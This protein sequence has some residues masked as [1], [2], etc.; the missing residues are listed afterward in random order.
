MKTITEIYEKVDE[1][2]YG[3]AEMLLIMSLGSAVAITLYAVL[4]AATLGYIQLFA[5]LT[6]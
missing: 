3:A 6:A 5:L 4:A 2:T 1:A